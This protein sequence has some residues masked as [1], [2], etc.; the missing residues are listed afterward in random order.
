M[1]QLS[2]TLPLMAEV[3]DVFGFSS[4][5]VTFLAA[6]FLYDH[7][8]FACILLLVVG[9]VVGLLVTAMCFA[10]IDERRNVAP[11]DEEP[12]KE[13]EEWLVCCTLETNTTILAS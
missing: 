6:A 12:E 1:P 3:S 11:M 9:I 8:I 13:K 10:V 7:P 5:K 2:L 4:K